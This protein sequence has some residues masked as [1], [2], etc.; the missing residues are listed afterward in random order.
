MLAEVRTFNDPQQHAGSILGWQQVYDQ[1]GRGCLSSELQQICAERFQIFQEVLDKRVVQRGCAPK[2]RLCIAMSL[3]SAPVVQG[4]QVDAHNV[5]LLRD[6]EDFVLHAPEGTRFF[7]INVDMVR[8]A[9]LAAYELPD[10]QLKRLKNVSQVSVDETVL[11]RVQQRIHPLFRRLLEQPDAIT[12]ASEKVLEDVLLDAF[13]DLF[14]HASDEVRGRRGNFA[15]SAYLVKRCQELVGDSDTSL[16]ILDLCEQLRVS[17]R[18]LQNSFQ[19]VTGMRPVEYLRNLRLNAVR[20][21]LITTQATAQ[22]VGE[23]AVA[24]GFFHLSHFA[25]HYRELFGESPSETPR[26][27]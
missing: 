5:V 3:G 6:G 7:A 11:L 8:F 22:N 23:I 20:R 12:P 24:M 15:V 21:R 9:K 14:S 4:H 19:A 16:S 18:T 17:R 26:V 2:G 13:L 10:E 25:T 1:L 27:R